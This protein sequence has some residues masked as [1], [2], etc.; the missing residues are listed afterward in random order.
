MDQPAEGLA[1]G[2]FRSYLR[3]LAQ[4]HLDPRLRGKVD[5]SDLVQQTLLQAHQ[6]RDSF[7]GQ[8]QAELAGWLRQILARNLAHAVRDLTRARRDV[9]RERSLEQAL[10]Q[11]SL[12]LETWAAA[13]ESS[14][15]EQ[16]QR[17]EQALRLAGAL[18]ALPEAQREAVVL[19]YWQDWPLADIGR[20]LGRSPAAV[21]GLLQ[22]GLQKLRTCL[23]EANEP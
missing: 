10:E 22:R 8:S 2:R 23:K 11:S 7:R 12:R 3:L 17:N 4:L 18:E 21:A 15:L 16:A 9:A 13:A 1:L 20:H 5:P 19:H 6:A 14:P